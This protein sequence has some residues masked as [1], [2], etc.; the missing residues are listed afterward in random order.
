LKSHRQD[1]LLIE[2][3]AVRTDRQLTGVKGWRLAM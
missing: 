3:D 1:P 2:Q